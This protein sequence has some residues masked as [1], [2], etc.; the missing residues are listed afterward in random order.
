MGLDNYKFN[1]AFKIQLKVI[2]VKNTKTTKKSWVMVFF[3]ASF[4][5]GLSKTIIKPL[6]LVIKNR[7]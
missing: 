3:F 4:M 1:M 6:T 2:K 5:S 7:G